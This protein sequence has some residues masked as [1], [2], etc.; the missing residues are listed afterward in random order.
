MPW[1]AVLP[2]LSADPVILVRGRSC[3][4]DSGSAVVDDRELGAAVH[5]LEGFA[6]LAHRPSG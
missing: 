6:G 5:W 1:R 2:N 3:R 4:I